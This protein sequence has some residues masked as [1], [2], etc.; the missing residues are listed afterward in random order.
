MRELSPSENVIPTNTDG[1][2]TQLN[3]VKNEN[4]LQK[5]ESL[6][7]SLSNKPK[8]NNNTL[9]KFTRTVRLRFKFEKNLKKD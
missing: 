7:T 4:T 2:N 9:K 8:I 5:L 6:D 3:T 1:P